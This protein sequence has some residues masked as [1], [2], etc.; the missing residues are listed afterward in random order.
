MKRKLTILITLAILTSLYF[1]YYSDEKIVM[2]KSELLIECFDKESGAKGIG[3]SNFRDL[4]YK[5]VAISLPDD[6]DDLSGGLPRDRASIAAI[7][8]GVMRGA[9]EISIV[10]KSITLDSISNKQAIV[11]ID[12]HAKVVFQNYRKDEDLS[13]KVIFIQSDESAN[14]GWKIKQVT[15]IEK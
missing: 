4:L 10:K 1:W 7:F 12:F 13:A 3:S 9:R 15:I 8:S 2:R 5:K 11:S 14:T 6:D